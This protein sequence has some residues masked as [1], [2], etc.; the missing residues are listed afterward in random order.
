MHT[1]S[2]SQWHT[3]TFH[4]KVYYIKGILHSSV[5]NSSKG[6]LLSIVRT[7]MVACKADIRMDRNTIHASA[8]ASLFFISIST[9][10]VF[11]ATEEKV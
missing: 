5:N 9:M 10:V 4:I 3:S 2:Y 7:L 11:C 1:V 8:S 6:T